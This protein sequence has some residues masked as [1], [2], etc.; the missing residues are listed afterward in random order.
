MGRGGDTVGQRGEERRVDRRE[1]ER[2]AMGAERRVRGE[3]CA[4]W[5]K[6]W[7]LERQRNFV[8]VR[9]LFLS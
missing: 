4:A 3:R 8:P 9:F 7:G 1:R 6:G 2:I 5:G